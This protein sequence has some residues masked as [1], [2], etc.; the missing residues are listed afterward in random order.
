MDRE[1]R[2][3]LHAWSGGPTTIGDATTASSAFG[4]RVL[5]ALRTAGL[6][7]IV[8]VILLPVPV[9]HLAG[10]G[11]FVACLGIAA[12]QLRPGLRITSVEGPCPHCGHAQRY[13]LGLN[14]GPMRLPKGTSCEK[15]A[16]SI[17]IDSTSEPTS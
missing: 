3:L 16:K 11:F 13:W 7:L 1:V 6:G 17:T 9:I 10:I 15:C 12:W 4:T 2:L 14:V 8:A 5:K